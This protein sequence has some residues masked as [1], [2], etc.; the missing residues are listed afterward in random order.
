MSSEGPRQSKPG[1]PAP[2]AQRPL[3]TL[4]GASFEAQT[5]LCRH[6][7]SRHSRFL[8]SH[9]E[10][11]EAE[12]GEAP[13]DQPPERRQ[14]KGKR[15]GPRPLSH[16]RAKKSVSSKG[17]AA[18]PRPG[19]LTLSKAVER[20]PETRTSKAVKSLPGCSTTGLSH[21]PGSPLLKKGPP[22]FSG[23]PPPK[24]SE[25]RSPLPGS[26]KAQ[27]PQPEDEGPLNLS[28]DGDLGRELDGLLSRAHFETTKDPSPQA[29]AH[30]PQPG[31]SHPEA[32]GSPIDSGFHTR[33]P[34]QREGQ[35]EPGRPEFSARWPPAMAPLLLSPPLAKKPKPRVSG[36]AGL[37]GKW[38]LPANA[39]WA[40]VMELALL[41]LSSDTGPAQH[42]GCELCGQLFDNA[43]GLASHANSHLQEMGVREW[44]VNNS[45]ID[46]LAEILKSQTQAQAGGPPD[47]TSPGP[48][49]GAEAMGGGPGDSLEAPSAAEPHV[50]P[51]ARKWDPSSDPL[52]LSL[53][54]SS[55]ST[56]RRKFPGRSLHSLQ[57]K[58]KSEP[59]RV[60][61]KQETLVVGLQ[62]KGRPS[63]GPGSPR[64]DK[65]P[66]NLASWAEPVQDIRCQ[67][68]G[69]FFRDRRGLSCHARFH[70]RR[71]GVTEWYGSPIDKLQ[72]IL[73]K[74]ANVGLIKKKPTPTELP[75]PRGE[76]GPK[77]PG[78]GPLALSLTPLPRNP[79][80]PRPD[81]ANRGQKMTLSPLLS[82][83]IAGFLTP[84]RTKRPPPDDQLLHGEKKT[85]TCTCREPPIKTEPIPSQSS[86]APR[87]ARCELCRLHFENRQAL[88]SHAQAHLRQLGVTGWR[89][90][91]SPI[92]TLREWIKR[93]PQK[94]RAYRSHIPG[95]RPPLGMSHHSRPKRDGD[96]RVPLT[97]APNRLTLT[98]KPLG[99]ESG[100]GEGGR[101][102]D[103]GTGPLVASPPAVVKA[104]ENQCHNVHHGGGQQAWPSRGEAATDS[105]QTLVPRRQP[106][107]RALP[108]NSLLPPSV[109]SRLR[110][111]WYTLKCRFRK[112]QFQG[113]LSIQ[114]EWIHH[115][116]RHILERSSSRAEPGPVAPEAPE[117][118]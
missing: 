91:G 41:S 23:P 33:L 70:L 19:P 89:L 3:C 18:S 103:G 113:P 60:E 92:E 74:R 100:P 7:L 29:R 50:P 117:A 104:E 39:F 65:A 98:D 106:P 99:S 94:G 2:K 61:I 44:H 93:N 105:Q 42:I 102:G 16:P 43:H 114:K 81:S 86:H 49:A 45:P 59:R 35:A 110:G 30:L 79:D 26:S 69:E 62:D 13:T 31:M 107:P 46:T 83:P 63:D 95:G 25:D 10:P 73:E 87:E 77:S 101:A 111:P 58:L 71:M 64:E 67:L 52:G 82:D 66:Q 8:A 51:P 5:D 116:Q 112:V 37:P 55:H 22:A 97:W 38:D 84:L 57:E 47:P 20:P 1:P 21:P 24:N 78:K 40:P 76:D 109:L 27:C 108:T 48:K 12:S 72:E 4:C 36:E 75:C 115:L 15:S 80:K 17:A 28:L 85:K 34:A 68:C 90:K 56:A 96:K 14:Q 11:S 9:P 6:V 54:T 53:T 118:Q 32:K 88:A